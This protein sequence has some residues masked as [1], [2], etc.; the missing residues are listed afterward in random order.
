MFVAVICAVEC[1]FY[2][3]LYA[4]DFIEYQ[5]IILDSILKEDCYVI[6]CQMLG[7]KILIVSMQ[8]E[9][10]MIVLLIQLNELLGNYKCLSAAV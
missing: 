4:C 5:I 6:G 1:H 8:H 3:V 9:N 7:V 2:W 10:N